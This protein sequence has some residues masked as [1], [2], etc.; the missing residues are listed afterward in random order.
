MRAS[1][2]FALACGAAAAVACEPAAAANAWGGS[3]CLA[4]GEGGADC[5]FTSLAQ[6]QASASG[7]L[8]GCYA[9]PPSLLQ[10]QGASTLQAVPVQGRRAARAG[11]SG[12]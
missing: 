5:G 1:V 6:C 3:Y 9:A 12:Q 8:S 7:T 11:R 4:Y 10:Q 2:M